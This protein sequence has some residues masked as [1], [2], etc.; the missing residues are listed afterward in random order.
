MNVQKLF[1]KMLK[2]NC[3]NID[4]TAIIDYKNAQELLKYLL[5]YPSTYIISI[6]IA[7][8]EWK[9]YDGAYLITLGDDNSIYC[10]PA[11]IE[12]T[13]EPARGAGLFYIDTNAIG[14]H[15]PEDFVLSQESEIK[16]I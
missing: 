7:Q 11:I 13:G 10:Q 12:S 9:G 15:L 5:T 3:K 1:A 14:E 8:S 16:L 6:E 2:A 4:V